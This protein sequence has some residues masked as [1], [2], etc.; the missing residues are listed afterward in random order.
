MF[1]QWTGYNNETY[2]QMDFKI[3]KLDAKLAEPSA[4]IL[5]RWSNTLQT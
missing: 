3:G 4:I 5:G 2:S 1:V